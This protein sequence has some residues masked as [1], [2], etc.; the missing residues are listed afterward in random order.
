VRPNR[1]P[2]GAVRNISSGEWQ[3]PDRPRRARADI[4]DRGISVGK[5]RC[6]RSHFDH[7]ASVLCCCRVWRVKI[8]QNSLIAI[9]AR[10]IAEMSPFARACAAFSPGLRPSDGQ[11][12][13]CVRAL[14]CFLSARR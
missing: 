12:D 13:A 2:L 5:K 6:R 14:S 1:S 3:P 4:V 10:R 8:A 9:F 11:V 7:Y